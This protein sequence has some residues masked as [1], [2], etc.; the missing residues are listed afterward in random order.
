MK[1]KVTLLP[2]AFNEKFNFLDK[3]RNVLL[4]DGDAPLHRYIYSESIDDCL[5]K[6]CEDYLKYSCHWLDIHLVGFRRVSAEEFEAVYFCQFPFIEG[7]DKAGDKISLS[8]N[9]EISEIED[10]YVT[11]VSTHTSRRFIP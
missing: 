7:F 9:E 8:L 1:I 11:I 6:L 10:Y 3:K 5:A 2:V 4:V